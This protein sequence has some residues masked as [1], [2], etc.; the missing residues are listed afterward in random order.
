[1]SGKHVEP[2]TGMRI[3]YSGDM[4]NASD[5]GTITDVWS[6]EYGQ[7]FDVK[8][9]DG[10]VSRGLFVMM[11]NDGEYERFQPLESYEARR[12]ARIAEFVA[13]YNNQVSA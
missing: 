10:R 2:V 8:F 13:K 11:L 12:T 1:M 3:Y 5:F 7:F 9:D 4:A 6:S